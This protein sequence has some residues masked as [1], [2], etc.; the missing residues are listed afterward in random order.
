MAPTYTEK[1][2]QWLNK[3]RK[4]WLSLFYLV[5]HCIHAEEQYASFLLEVELAKIGCNILQHVAII[6]LII[7]ID[8]SQTSPP[9]PLQNLICAAVSTDSQ[10]SLSANRKTALTY[11][12]FSLSC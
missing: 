8:I 4:N 10:L 3:K 12:H 6:S 2:K 5:N 1:G 7:G 11:P 9:H